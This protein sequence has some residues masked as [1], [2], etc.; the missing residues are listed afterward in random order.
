MYRTETPLDASVPHCTDIVPYRSTPRRLRQYRAC[1]RQVVPGAVRSE[2]WS[3]TPHV[4]GT[5]HRLST[6]PHTSSTAH[7]THPVP[8]M[9]S[10][11]YRTLHSTA[12]ARRIPGVARFAHQQYRTPHPSVL[13]T[14]SGYR[15]E[16]PGTYGSRP[17]VVPPRRLRQCRA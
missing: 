5:T 16:V 17:A 3:C 9:T 12:T 2:E 14:V 11:Q 10:P 1:G 15:R 6:A 7:S 13:P 8:R 4:P